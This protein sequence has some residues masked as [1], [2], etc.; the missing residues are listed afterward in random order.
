MM[1]KDKLAI[2]CCGCLSTSY[3]LH[4]CPLLTFQFV[5]FA[6]RNFDH[7]DESLWLNISV[8]GGYTR[9]RNVTF[10][11]QLVR[12]PWNGVSN[13]RKLLEENRS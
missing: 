7:Q 2:N 13:S 8:P 12:P 9:S 10:D 6:L 11:R 1:Q 5:I 4:S 3:D